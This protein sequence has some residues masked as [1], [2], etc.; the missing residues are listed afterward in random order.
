[1]TASKWV[2]LMDLPRDAVLDGKRVRY[3]TRVLGYIRSG[4]NAGLWLT[5][6]PQKWGTVQPWF[7]PEGTLKEAAPFLEV[8]A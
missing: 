7:P 1:M 4:W 3:K 8:E 5:S 6:T 2:K